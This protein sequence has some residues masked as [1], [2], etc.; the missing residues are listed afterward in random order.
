MKLLFTK[1]LPTSKGLEGTKLERF[2][3]KG[4]VAT[5][6]SQP[7]PAKEGL[8]GTKKWLHLRGRGSYSEPSLFRP[9]KV[10]K[11]LSSEKEERSKD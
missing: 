7:L 8:E 2:P 3:M 4:T 11:A 10:L 6:I 5:L 1:S 9:K